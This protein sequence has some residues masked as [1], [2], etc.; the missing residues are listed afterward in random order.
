[1]KV[2]S[3]GAETMLN[4]TCRIAVVILVICASQSVAPMGLALDHLPAGTGGW[5]FDFTGTNFAKKPGDDFFRY[6]NGDW[7]DRVVIP[8][9]RS[10]IGPSTLLT[11]TAE[12]RIRE[13]LEQAQQGDAPPAQTDASKIGD[14]YGAFMDEA[15]AEALD[16]RPIAALIAMVRDRK[17]VV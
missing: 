6:A 9:D 5:G 16:V 4:L 17:S 14:F 10:S 2:A 1:M 11:M 15:R 13:I 7:Y 3:Y 8:A 12:A